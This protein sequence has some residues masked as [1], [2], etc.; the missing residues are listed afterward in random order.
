MKISRFLSIPIALCISFASLP[1]ISFVPSTATVE[2]AT[3]GDCGDNLT[4][5]FADGILTISGTGTMMEG[6]YY[7]DYPWS[8]IRSEIIKVV[9]EEGVTSIGKNAFRIASVITS[10][11]LPSTMK[12][13]GECAFA[14]CD[15]LTSIEVAESNPY[16]TSSS[17]VLY[18]KEKTKLLIYPA[19]KNEK[20]YTIFN[21]VTSIGDYAFY[22]CDRLQSITIPASVQEIGTNAFGLCESL[23]QVNTTKGLLSIGDHAFGGCYNLE[24]F[25]IPET[26]TNIG[27]YA[28]SSCTR[29]KTVNLPD[30][31]T[32]IGKYAFYSCNS[33]DNIQIPNSITRLNDG[34][35]GQCESLRS[36]II[37]KNITSIGYYTFGY[38]QALTSVVIFGDTEYIGD[39]AFAGCTSLTT[40]AINSPECE[41]FDDK[42]TIYS[43]VAIYGR[44]GSTSQTY[45][46]K[47][48]RQFYE[49]LNGTC[50]ENVEW[51][52]AGG[53]LTISGNGA[54]KD[55]YWYHPND[56]LWHENKDNIE[57]INIGEGITAIGG[58]AFKDCSNLKT[59]TI[60]DSVTSIGVYAFCNCYILEPFTLPISVISIGNSAFEDCRTMKSVG[61]ENPNC[62][63]FSAKYTLHS[64][65]VIYGYKGSTAENYAK[66][67]S[68]E[69][70]ECNTGSCGKSLTW[71][72]LDGVLTISGTG[73]MTDYSFTVAPP[74][75]KYRDNI[76]EV[77]IEYGVTSIGAWAFRYYNNISSVTIPKSIESIGTWAFGDCYQLTSVILPENVTNVDI[78]AFENCCNLKSVTIYN[79]NCEIYEHQNTVPSDIIYG[80]QNSTA[81]S[82]A[83]KYGVTFIPIDN[84]SIKGDINADGLLTV[85]DM[86]LL[87][88]WLL[89]VS[90]VTL[91]DLKTADVY[92]DGKLNVF[93]L[94]TMKQN[95]ISNK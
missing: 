68:R 70:V 75:E 88:K 8:N 23:I 78:V 27:A 32:D 48:N 26:V 85:A 90:N 82:Y 52:L 35:F 62:E 56:A 53:T 34:V 73:A 67:Y 33:L 61:I 80:Y 37:P 29:L 36:I 17:G 41:I 46:E 30:G 72:Y 77:V 60:P 64:S 54:I 91:T 47:Y 79:P 45:A 18:D 44:S 74:W 20:R 51:I 57:R 16:F 7:S 12:S 93:D 94:C 63:I 69:F 55:Y 83:K 19:G 42:N 89:G 21:G 11:Q 71:K 38:C 87:K 13:I 4:W 59:I 6:K 76:T 84:I 66:E 3:F 1:M 31:L 2:T 50:G 28:F 9:I 65:S 14:D 10:V 43:N 95:L 22:S 92:E 81:E 58:F 40:I 5:R 24:I 86:L 49:L 15:G 25:D 39:S